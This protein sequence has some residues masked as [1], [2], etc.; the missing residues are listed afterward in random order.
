MA[1]AAK[2]LL[3]DWWLVHPADSAEI[4]ELAAAPSSQTVVWLDEL[5][6][7]LDGEHGLP[8]H[9]YPRRRHRTQ[10]NLRVVAGGALSEF[11]RLLPS[12]QLMLTAGNVPTYADG[13][14]WHG[15]RLPGLAEAGR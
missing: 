8:L 5:Q 15:P 2:A 9:G 14:P 4:V 1:E 3:P 6:D 13:R 10:P 12:R 11:K 7:Y